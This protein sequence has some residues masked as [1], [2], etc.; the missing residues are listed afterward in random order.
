[1]AGIMVKGLSPSAGT[2]VAGRPAI[3]LCDMHVLLVED[4]L[5]LG[6]SLQ[7]A[8][9]GAGIT[10]E[11]VRSAADARRFVAGGRFDALLLDL[12]LPDGHGLALLRDWR[13]QGVRT[14]LI[15]I[16]ASD[17]LGERLS[18]LDEGADDFLVKPF[19]VAELVSR[20]HA[21]TRR[22]AQQAGAVWTLGALAI[23]LP[24]RECRLDGAPVHL[25][26]REFDVLAALAR[27]AGAVVPKHRLAQAVAPLGEALDFNAVEVHVHNLRRKLAPGV[28]RTVRGVGYQIVVE[29]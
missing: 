27:A 17:G 24:R 18:G 9:R 7:Q 5:A 28:I 22:A 25:A 6:A 12:T 19:V 15:V 21:V 8:L 1:M 10:S 2:Q 14:P 11:W 29:P 4:D 3:T 16:S 26:P 13:G 20:L 23:D